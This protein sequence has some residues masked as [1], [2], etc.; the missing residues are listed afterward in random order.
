MVQSKEIDVTSLIGKRIA[1]ADSSL[2]NFSV[3]LN[4]GSGLQ[5][6]AVDEEGEARLLVTLPGADSL[7]NAKEAVCAVDWSWIYDS[8]IKNASV[9]SA[10]VRLQMDPAGPLTISVSVWQGSP[11]LAFQPF[12]PPVK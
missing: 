1:R 5:I 3:A 11:F 4:D 10:R 2:K 9:D 6:D 8:T 12:K 7:P